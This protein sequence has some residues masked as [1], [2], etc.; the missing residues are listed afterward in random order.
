[1]QVAPI[2]GSDGTKR[3]VQT[4]SGK[5]GFSIPTVESTWE[6]KLNLTP[7]Y[8]KRKDRESSQYQVNRDI[9]NET[10]DKEAQLIAAE[11]QKALEEKYQA[12]QEA[13]QVKLQQERLLREQEELV[14]K[15]TEELLLKEQQCRAE[16]EKE[17]TLLEEQQ[18][19]TQ[20]LK[21]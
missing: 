21:D 1:M 3:K 2:A 6:R 18:R 5:Q 19:K 11:V 9:L 4:P 16:L 12:E 10:V 7:S 20:E 8:E 17:K 15:Q 14:R 13:I